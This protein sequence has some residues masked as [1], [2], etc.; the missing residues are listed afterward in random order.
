MLTETEAERAELE[1]L[2]Y[3][4]SAE[5][6]DP[7]HILMV[8]KIEVTPLMVARAL[9][10]KLFL[11]PLTLHT[12]TPARLFGRPSLT[13]LLARKKE[14]LEPFEA[15]PVPSYRKMLAV[16]RSRREIKRLTLCR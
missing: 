1:S 5:E 6:G 10:Q 8:E 16:S 2:A 15:L 9:S 12:V 3:L 7:Q 11:G 13:V 14:Y 4:L